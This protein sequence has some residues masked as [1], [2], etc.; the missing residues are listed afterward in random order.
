MRGY[1]YSVRFGR[2]TYSTRSHPIEEGGHIYEG[3]DG[4]FGGVWRVS[5]CSSALVKVKDE[6]LDMD[7]GG[8]TSGLGAW[9]GGM[10]VSACLIWG[11]GGRSAK[12]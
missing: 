9:W 12:R 6:P 8:P 4:P 5:G 2:C 11:G 10:M 7:T 1:L 3:V